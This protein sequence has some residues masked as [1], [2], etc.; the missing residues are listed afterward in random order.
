MSYILMTA[1]TSTM[2]TAYDVL[3]IVYDLIFLILY[4]QA[5]NNDMHFT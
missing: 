2:D 5:I 4:L 3:T 1:Y